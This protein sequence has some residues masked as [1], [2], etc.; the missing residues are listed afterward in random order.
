MFAPQTHQTNGF[1]SL[2]STAF[3]KMWASAK[4]KIT[5]H[6]YNSDQVVDSIDDA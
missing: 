4:V 6:D 2:L 5:S 1:F 3:K